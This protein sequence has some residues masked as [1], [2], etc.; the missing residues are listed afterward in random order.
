MWA[1]QCELPYF[2]YFL[3]NRMLQCNLWIMVLSKSIILEDNMG[4]RE[5][6]ASLWLQRK[7]INSITVKKFSLSLGSSINYIFSLK[8]GHDLF[9]NVSLGSLI[10]VLNEIDFLGI[11][12]ITV[13]TKGRIKGME[14]N[15][16]EDKAKLL[17]EGLWHRLPRSKE[18]YP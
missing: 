8:N 6:Y 13:I 9:F 15:H 18:N 5:I 12:Q 11:L 17:Q 3:K 10:A 4:L 14:E 2:A 7:C 16:K 1:L